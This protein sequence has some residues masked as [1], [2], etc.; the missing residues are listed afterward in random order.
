[1][2]AAEASKSASA[3]HSG[4]HE[5]LRS[6]REEYLEAADLRSFVDHHGARIADPETAYYV[7]QA[8]EECATSR[9]I[10]GGERFSAPEREAAATLAAH[11]RGFVGLI[12][13]PRAIIDLL[14]YAARWG[15]PHA[16]ARM[17]M[18]RDIAASKDDV[19]PLLPW[20]LTSREPS[21][22]REVG[23][24]IS[25]GEAQWRYGSEQVPT[26]VAAI[27]WDLAAC[28]LDGSCAWGRFALGQCAFLGRCSAGRYEDA[29][30]LLEPPELMAQARV[31]RAGILRA[32]RDHDWEWLGLR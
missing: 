25:R 19:L 2:P 21:I 12:I 15:E 9:D 20:M 29:L 8:L 6:V 10:S 4:A 31:L 14:A 27:A 3:A 1:M 28:D 32:L 13:D 5:R 30:A 18:L 11:C 23:A 22:V 26:A 17:L 24:F 16:M 7:S